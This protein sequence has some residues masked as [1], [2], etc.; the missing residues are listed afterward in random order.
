MLISPSRG[1]NRYLSSLFLASVF[2]FSSPAFAKDWTQTFEC[3]LITADMKLLEEADGRIS[4]TFT[5]SIGKLSLS[6]PDVA[7]FNTL[8]TD[9]IQADLY[10]TCNSE[11]KDLHKL[12]EEYNK[13]IAEA[14]DDKAREKVIASLNNKYTKFYDKAVA[15]ME[16]T[17]N[18]EFERLRKRSKALAGEK[19]NVVKNL[20]KGAFSIIGGIGSL[21]SSGGTSIPGYVSVLGGVVKIVN[22]LAEGTGNMDDAAEELDRALAELGASTQKK[23]LEDSVKRVNKARKKYLAQFRKLEKNLVKSRKQLDEL[24]NKLEADQ[25]DPRFQNE[26]AKQHFDE[27]APRVMELIDTVT[28]LNEELKAGVEHE[29][30]AEDIEKEAKK[31]AKALQ[32]K[33]KTTK[34]EAALKLAGVTGEW[35]D[36][37]GQMA[38]ALYLGANFF[39]EHYQIAKDVQAWTGT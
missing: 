33:E 7:S 15:Y 19:M 32:K 25:K 17:A 11:R 22:N 3:D 18:K 27:A 34:I 26:N 2:L 4:I 37:V 29:E 35:G 20:A 16:K 13:K 39:K 30:G 28:T 1:I 10:K 38:D 31:T 21:L 8:Y 9:V 5:Q 6:D 24:L 14:K 23:T 12:M 36:K